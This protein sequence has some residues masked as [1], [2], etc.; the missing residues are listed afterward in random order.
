MNEIKSRLLTR[1]AGWIG[2]LLG[3]FSLWLPTWESAG[4]SRP[5]DKAEETRREVLPEA[6]PGEVSEESEEESEADP[7]DYTPLGIDLGA[8][9]LLAGQED[10][11][12]DPSIEGDPVQIDPALECPESLAGILEGYIGKPASMG[13]LA[14]LARD[15][16]ESWR[17]S[18]Y[19][20]VDVYFPEQNVTEGKIQLVVR[21]A[22]L[23][24]VRVEGAKHTRPEYLRKQLRIDPGGR[25]NKRQMSEDLEWMNYNRIRSVNLVFEQG[26]EDGTSNIV[27]MTEEDHAL[28]FYTGFANTGLE[29]TGENEWAFG[30]NLANPFGTEQ[31]IG[32]NFG[33]DEDFEGLLAH[34]LFYEGYLPWRHVLRFTGAVVTS[35]IGPEN[36]LSFGDNLKGESTQATIDY[37]VP[38]RQVA[39]FEG[40]RHH[41]LLG[42]D[43]K[44]TNSDLIF[45]GVEIFES[46][47]AIFQLRAEYEATVPDSLGQTR[48]RVTSVYSPGDVL[49]NNDD[50]AFE[51]LRFDSSAS[52]WYGQAEIERSLRLP[53][54]FWLRVKGTGQF[55]DARLIS[56]EQILGGGYLTVRGFQENAIRGDSGALVRT[57]LISPTLNLLQPCFP[58]IADEWTFYGFYDAA[59]LQITDSAPGV[60]DPSLQSVGVGLTCR[61]ADHFFGRLS[62]GWNVGE[63]GL[64]G[65][66]PDGKLHFGVTIR[67]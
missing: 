65:E 51:T 41:L 10:A 47:A 5:L 22:L 58:E 4:Q 50:A 33:A 6:E 14:D 19:P 42:V 66:S 9:H 55:T 35:E 34:S 43:T 23:G 63:D 54:D 17:E 67:R 52:Y 32:Y 45:G 27:L 48:V 53:G 61:I 60:M 64:I 11:S 36:G 15:I 7:K 25:I 49:N 30:L 31:S 44:T 21:E 59:F 40:M 62:Y 24:E 12:D 3:V 20:V 57:E 46:D 29:S 13:L 16:V 39:R 1:K 28:S 37:L 26:E 2:L 18:D 8:I 56:T 38:L